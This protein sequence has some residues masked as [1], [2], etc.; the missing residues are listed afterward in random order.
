MIFPPQFAAKKKAEEEVA[1]K[2]AEEE[3]AAKKKGEEE[4]KKKEAL[5]GFPHAMKP[6]EATR[7]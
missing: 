3:A 4:A 1:K 7:M 2:K 6:P 5:E